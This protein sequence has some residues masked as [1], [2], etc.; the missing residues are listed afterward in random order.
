MKKSTGCY[1][2]FYLLDIPLTLL[3]CDF[4]PE[5]AKDNHRKAVRPE[6]KHNLIRFN[7]RI[8]GCELQQLL[9]STG[10]T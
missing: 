2:H 5:A 8:M 1:N 10:S 7:P 9:R 4:T 3:R 6:L